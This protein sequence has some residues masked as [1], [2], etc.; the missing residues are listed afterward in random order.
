ME[1]GL[2]LALA[3]LAAT[4]ACATLA[5]PRPR[6]VLLVDERTATCRIQVVQD[7]RSLACFVG[8]RCGRQ[9][10]VIVNADP[11]VCVP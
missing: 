9:P 1:R 11:A 6:F 2:A 3:V 5:R 8:F 10:I 7:T 4:A